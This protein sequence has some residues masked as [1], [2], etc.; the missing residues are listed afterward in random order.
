MPAL[1]TTHT[2]APLAR[3]CLRRTYAYDRTAQ[4]EPNPHEQ[5]T[6]I[7][8]L[9][10]LLDEME[11]RIVYDLRETGHSWQYVADALGVKHRQQVQA[12]FHDAPRCTY[13]GYG[14]SCLKGPRHAQ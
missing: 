1:R 6:A 9:R 13:I 3:A 5:L 2:L 7:R 8:E 11:R 12:K 4:P 14:T 10:D